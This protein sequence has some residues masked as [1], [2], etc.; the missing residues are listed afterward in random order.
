M[1]FMDKLNQKWISEM[2]FSSGV[3]HIREELI[4]VIWDLID[5]SGSQEEN[6]TDIW[7][8]VVDLVDRM[9]CKDLCMEE[10]SEK[11]KY[12]G[13]AL[14]CVLDRDELESIPYLEIDLYRGAH[15]VSFSQYYLRP[16]GL[17]DLSIP[18]LIRFFEI[19]GLKM[20]TN[21]I[22]L[23]VE[24]Q[25]VISICKPS[26]SAESTCSSGVPVSQNGPTM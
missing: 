15:E 9:M 24:F 13:S 12:S 18:N 8:E 14:A 2:L 23:P 7:R 16:D 25:V 10:F 5:D 3:D 4:R 21:R 20:V 1:A 22:E 17:E 6:D 26:S 19:G 11:R